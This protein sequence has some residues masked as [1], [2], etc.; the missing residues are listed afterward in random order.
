M[1]LSRKLRAIIIDVC[2]PSCIV[3]VYFARSKQTGMLSADFSKVY[4]IKFSKILPEGAEVFHGD[5]RTER[6]DKAY[7]RFLKGTELK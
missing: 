1:N 7:G 2:G 5:R 6:H 4:K 3:P